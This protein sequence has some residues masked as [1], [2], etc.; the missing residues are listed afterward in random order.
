MLLLFQFTL[1]IYNS[2]QVEEHVHFSSASWLNFSIIFGLSD[3]VW[4]IFLQFLQYL[5]EEK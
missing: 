4:Q 2:D 5:I 3:T 1:K